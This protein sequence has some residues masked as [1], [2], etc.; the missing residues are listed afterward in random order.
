MVSFCLRLVEVLTKDRGEQ[1][2]WF[3]QPFRMP[4]KLGVNQTPI[5]SGRIWVIKSVVTIDLQVGP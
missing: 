3:L 2:R 1:I 5:P 4:R